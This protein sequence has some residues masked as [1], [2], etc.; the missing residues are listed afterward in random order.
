M[1]YVFECLC[2][3]N[4]F[5]SKT[6]KWTC[7][8]SGPQIWIFHSL[9]IPYLLN[10]EEVAECLSL[11]LHFAQFVWNTHFIIQSPCPHAQVSSMNS[12]CWL[13]HQKRKMRQR[14]AMIYVTQEMHLQSCRE[15]K[16]WHKSDIYTTLP[17]K[18]FCLQH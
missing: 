13:V 3:K 18:L 4:V 16:L 11:L 2:F 9:L 10:T 5:T 15:N 14:W 8:F 12:T 7:F 6:K 1:F 17:T